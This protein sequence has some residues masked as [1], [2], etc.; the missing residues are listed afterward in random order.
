MVL[1][2]EQHVEW[3]SDLI[4]S[5]RD[6]GLTTAETTDVEAK[7]WTAHVQKAADATLYPETDS[8]FTGS[9][10]PGKP[11]VFMP[12]VGGVGRYRRTCDEIAAS[13]YKGFELR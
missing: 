1:S 4:G 12:Y 13:G 11:R 2:I 5:M 8:W 3:V 6:K 7:R 10:V 9:N